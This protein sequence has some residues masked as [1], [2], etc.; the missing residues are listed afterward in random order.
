[1]KKTTLDELRQLLTPACIR[2]MQI[3]HLSIM[4]GATFF[5]LFIVFMFF[6][7]RAGAETDFGAVDTVNTISFLNAALFVSCLFM[8]KFLDGWYY[9]EK[10]IEAA[11]AGVSDR[12]AASFYIGMVRTGKIIR[13]AVLEAPA[14]VGLVA[15]YMAIDSGVM[16]QYSHYWLNAAS[17]FGFIYLL[18]SDFPTQDNIIGVFTSRLK[19]LVVW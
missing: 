16:L 7:G 1:M 6:T 9:S 5:F 12:D 18:A 17:Y 14:F 3:I 11:A 15:C 4:S 10:R 13:M 8:S 19:F 2:T